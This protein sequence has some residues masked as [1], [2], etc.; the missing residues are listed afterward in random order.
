MM[1]DRIINHQA[2]II[3]YADDYVLMIFTTLPAMLLLLMMRRP[4]HA[5]AAETMPASE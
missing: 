2:Q 3:A 5:P 1:L 4:R